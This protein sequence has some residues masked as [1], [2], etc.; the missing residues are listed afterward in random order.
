[1]DI[2]AGSHIF[3]LHGAANRDP[4]KFENPS[5]FQLERPNARQHMAFGRGIH[6]CPGAPL[7]RSE[8]AVAI[9]QFLA[10]TSDIR[11]SADTHGP[12]GERRFSYVPSFVLRGLNRLAIEFE[13]RGGAA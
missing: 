5:E 4:K 13:P 3:L 12:A 6:T 10:R 11:L 2:A 7:V 1:V 8:G 9:E